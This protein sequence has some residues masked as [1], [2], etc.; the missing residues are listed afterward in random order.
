MSETIFEQT[1]LEY[2]RAAQEL[3]TA[4]K[5]LQHTANHFRNR[6]VPRACAHV[7]ATLG[8]MNQAR[9]VLERLMVEHA[10]K[11]SV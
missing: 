4:I 6:E 8:H 1:A 7:V 10:A 2:E 11:A 5:H 9:D 3:E